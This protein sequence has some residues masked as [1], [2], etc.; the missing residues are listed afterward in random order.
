MT[1]MNTLRRTPLSHRASE[2]GFTLVEMIVVSLLLLVAMLGLLA[3]FDA[4]ARINKNETD[5]ADAQGNVRYGIYQMTRVIRMAGTGGLYVTQAVLNHNDAELPGING[6]GTSFSFD[7]V[8]GVSVDDADGGPAIPVKNGTD[9]I[10]IRGVILSPLVGFGESGGCNGC[11]GTQNVQTAAVV[12]N[13]FSGFHQNDDAT[14]RPQFS[15]ID[16][17]TAGATATKPMFVI[18]EGTTEQHPCGGLVPDPSGRIPLKLASYPQ[19]NYNVGL[20]TAPT[21]LVSSAS[22]GS[23]DF[24]GTTG[25]R[26]NIE[27]PSLTPGEPAGMIKNAAVRRA[28][29]L[30]DILFFV[31][32][33]PVN[34]PTGLHP[35]LAQGIRRGDAFEI[36]RL[37]DDVEDM[38]VAYGLDLNGDQ[39]VSRLC[40]VG[41]GDDDPNV[42]IAANCDEWRPNVGAPGDETNPDDAEFQSQDPFVQGHLGAGGLHCP[43]LHAVMVSLLAK[44][45]DPDPTYKAPGAQGVK[46]MNSSATPVTG[47]FRRR[48]QTLKINLRNYSFQ[49]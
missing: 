41:G 7:N 10:E 31:G 44:A 23:V 45:K 35:F 13:T 39:A 15:A 47:N 48:V 43:R 40:P 11:Q 2:R 30:D 14:N 8:N 26:F 1:T 37:A 28:G 3:V 27:L 21:D 29:V 33:D 32:T 22:F 6:P 25:P 19:F 4:S 12:G 20:L 9:M 17:Y 36:T 42:S 49:G 38:Q 18:V 5:V 24:G 46:I 16:A 34:D